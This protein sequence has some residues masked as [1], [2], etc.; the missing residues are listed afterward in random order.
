[1]NHANISLFH[2]QPELLLISHP[3]ERAE[4]L[5]WFLKVA[6]LF[7]NVFRPR[8]ARCQAEI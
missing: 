1:V 7:V 6:N 4:A 8:I 5:R 2:E 3:V